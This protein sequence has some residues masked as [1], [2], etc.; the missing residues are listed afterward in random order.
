MALLNDQTVMSRRV[1][2]C[3]R[4]AMDPRIEEIALRQ[5]S[6]VAY[7]QARAAGLSKDAVVHLH[8]RGDLVRVRRGLSRLA[9]VAPSWRQEVMGAVLSAGEPAWASHD[10]ALRLSGFA[11]LDA[12]PI[13]ITVPLERR[14]RVPGVWV[15]RSGTL[16]A[17]DLREIDGIPTLSVA[18][19]IADLSGRLEVNELERLVDDGL[20]RGVL[21]L[22]ALDRV[23]RRLARIAPGRSPQ[24]LAQ[25]LA[26]RVPGYHA[27]GSELEDRVLAA[28]VG[29][30][31]PV[32]VRQHKVVVGSHTY[33]VDLAY[34][35]RLI[36]IEVDGFAFH[37]GR[38][39]FDADRRRQ[40]DLAAAGWIVLRFTSK[41][42][43]EEIVKAVRDLL[44]GHSVGL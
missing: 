18:R 20:R 12:D 3:V 8:D 23:T 1:R 29:A 34:P 16:E 32:P 40:N 31:L 11:G 17:S 28:I 37:S 30:G 22:R 15:H 39:A 5:F 10:T 13:E 19:T 21:N 2:G 4:W 36:A 27:S 7:R 42:T 38:N 24:R 44:F 41:S 26:D 6:L 25:V 33:Y 43:V 9:G 14:T 35:E